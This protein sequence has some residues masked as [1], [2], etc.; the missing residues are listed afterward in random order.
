MITDRQTNKKSLIGVFENLNAI[1]FPTSINLAVYAKLADAQ[2]KYDFR[3]RLVR[4]KDDVMLTEL[5]IK[6]VEVADQLKSPELAINMTGF[7]IPEP[8]KYEFQLY[9][10]NVYLSRITMEA[11]SVQLPGG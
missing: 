6:G 5:E 11:F 1:R 10:N 2:G 3:I 4:L 9:A 7:Q 8:G